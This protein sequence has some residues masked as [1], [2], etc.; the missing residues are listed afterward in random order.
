M[1]DLDR[2]AETFILEARELLEGMETIILDL[3]KEP[4]DK[5]SVNRLFRA[6][7]TLKGSGAMFGFDDIAEFTHHVESALDCVRNDRMT[8]TDDLIDLVLKSRDMINDMVEAA[9]HKESFPKERSAKLAEEIIRLVPST[10]RASMPPAS[11]AEQASPNTPP[12]SA[13]PDNGRIY[14]IRFVPVAGIFATGMDPAYLIEDLGELG[15][16]RVTPVLGQIPPLDALDPDQC[17]IS[18]DVILET[19][20]PQSAIL[21]VFAFVEDD[22]VIEVSD[23]TP[24]AEAQPP[25]LGEILTNKGDAND[26]MIQEILGKQQR[27]GELLV[28]E[29]QVPPERVEA[30][31]EEQ[32]VLKKRIRVEN[33]MVRVPS[34]KL[35][36]LINL[37]GELVISQSQLFQIAESAAEPTLKTAIEDIGRLTA[38][39]RDVALNVRMVPIGTTFSRFRRLVR[40]LSKELSKEINLV[41]EGADTEVDKLVIDRLADPLIHLIRNSVDHGIELPD[42]RESKGKAKAGLIKLSAF[43]RGAKVIIRIEDDGRGLNTE[44]I[45]QKA[46]AQGLISENSVLSEHDI[47]QLILAPGFSTAEK[48]SN[49]SG[50]GVGMDVVSK[51]IEALRGSVSISSTFGRGST[52]ELALP[53][54]LAIIDG[55]LVEV[56]GSRYIIPINVV[57]ECINMNSA[58]NTSSAGKRMAAFRGELMPVIHLRDMFRH[59]TLQTGNEETVIVDAGGISVCIVVDR[60]VGKQQIVIKPLGRLFK[61]AKGVSG[62]TIMGNGHVAP[63][64]DIPALVQVFAG[65]SSDSGL[66]L[67][68]QK[69]KANATLL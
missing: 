69:D 49:I 60:I 40:D 67:K 9:A 55:L 37:V 43:H 25:R 36:S 10:V 68:Q 11:D 26:R 28:K 27:I 34:R 30:A 7:H 59:N 56:A 51:E 61:H 39:M 23:I 52:I 46:S 18:W 17:F 6:M 31:L 50:R 20:E 1:S 62:A 21:D 35:D 12:Q 3:E 54:T 44:K 53:L 22:S 14:R 2:F 24:T 48:V 4:E 58:H 64:L 66:S 19:R 5:D 57:Q 42:E 41:T 13:T 63:I 38:R 47:H 33:E 45:R 16:C 32:N 29:G 15:Q 65:E 8:V